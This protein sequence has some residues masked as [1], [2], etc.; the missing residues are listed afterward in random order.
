MRIHYKK[1]WQFE[2]KPLT[3]RSTIGVYF[4]PGQESQRAARGANHVAT[5][6]GREAPTASSPSA[7]RSTRTSRRWR[8][9]PDQVPPNITLQVEA[10]KPDGSRAPM[11]RLN[12]RPDWDR[13]YWFQQPIALPRGTKVE[14]TARLEDPD[15]LSA[16]FS[17]AAPAKT[18]PA[19]STVRLA[20]N[21]V[22][23]HSKPAAP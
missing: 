17:A 1:T 18:A 19:A 14:V 15:V 13:R 12:T 10:V 22:P 11:I 4:A 20:L 2:G 8:C 16:A 5:L 7:R 3:D 6:P 23:A 21:V 9:S